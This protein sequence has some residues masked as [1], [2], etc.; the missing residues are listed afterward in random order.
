MATQNSRV[1]KSLGTVLITGGCG[2]VGHKLAKLLQDRSAYTSLSIV[3]LRPSTT[4]LEKV[5]YHFGDITDYAAMTT[6][7]EKVRP[8]VVLHTAS[9]HFN[10]N[11]KEVMYKVNVE[12]TKT[13][14]K[15][16]QETGVKAFVY[17]SSSSVVSDTVSDLVNADEEYPLQMGPDQP[18]YYT[19]TKAMAEQL[20]LEANRT[21]SA[22]RFLTCSLRPAGIFGE[23]DVQ[24][25]PNALTVHYRGQTG[26]Q[27]GDNNNLF[28]FTEVTNVVHAH[29]LAA[30]ALLATADREEQGQSLPIDTEKVDGEAFFITN[31]QPTYFFDF[32]RM[33]WGA[34]GSTTDPKKVWVLNRDLAMF[35][36]TLLEWIYWI[37]RKGTP[38]LDRQRVRY[39]CMTRYFDITK[40]KSRLGYSPIISIDEGIKR[41]VA[42][43]IRRGA[44]P[45]MAEELK[46]KVP[47]RLRKQVEEL[48]KKRR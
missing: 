22:P 39:T 20:V 29:H 23:G 40:A 18:E 21:P 11:N 9:P 14:L 7:F 46:G 36:A 32:Y 17:T 47:E 25:L 3:D 10:I 43:V 12:G 5:D 13:L 2:F 34:A 1:T 16:A 30:A 4:P 37:L 26:F 44:V 28:D 45:G 33:V 24:N 6:I 15:V 8:H 35:I 42:D 19:T 31:D 38:N 27:V 41:G 48:D